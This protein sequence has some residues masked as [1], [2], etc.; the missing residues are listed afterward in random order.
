M[1][2]VSGNYGHEQAIELVEKAKSRFN[3]SS[4]KIEDLA[5]IRSMAVDAGHSFHVERSL[6]DTTNENSC[7]VTYYEVGIQG[8]SLKQKL[9]NNV[10]MQFL[11]EPFF[12]QLRTQQQLGYVVFSRAVNT[13]DVL[14]A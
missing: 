2:S 9:T 11:N 4:I 13:R 6:V 12:N 14:G 10:V 1:W 3:L 5:D 8:D 7:A